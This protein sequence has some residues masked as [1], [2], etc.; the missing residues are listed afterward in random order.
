MAATHTPG[1]WEVRP[2]VNDASEFARVG[3]MPHATVYNPASEPMCEEDTS[4]A[5]LIAA[6]P[7]L[8]A[9]L[10]RVDSQCDLPDGLRADVA[11]AIATAA[12]NS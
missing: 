9:V 3:F 5:R 8:L 1:P 4:N 6:A 12:G 2:F 7:D 11:D 10:R